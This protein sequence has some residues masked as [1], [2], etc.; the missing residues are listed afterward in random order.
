MPEFRDIDP[1]ELR[2]PPSRQQG[3]DPAKLQ[4]QIALYGRSTAGMPPLIVYESSD[5]ELVVY[6]GVTRA[7]RAAKLNPGTL[8]HVEIAG[9]LNRAFASQPRIGDVLP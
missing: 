5:G 2:L 7:T 1:R 3:A 9:R 4:R 6:N 8:I